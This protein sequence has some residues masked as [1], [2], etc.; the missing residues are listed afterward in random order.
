MKHARLSFLPTVLACSLTLLAA[1]LSACGDGEGGGSSGARPASS[2]K[3]A[4]KS[5]AKGAAKGAGGPAAKPAASSAMLAYELAQKHAKNGD[6]EQAEAEFRHAF[7][8]DPKMAEAQFELGRLQTQRAARKD[9]PDLQLLDQGIAAFAKACE[10]E[11]S[12]DRYRL[13]LGRA[14]LQ[15]DDLENAVPCLEKAL[16]LNPKSAGVWKALGQAQLA[17]GKAETGRDSLR[18]ALELNPRDAVANQLLAQ[19]LET[20]GDLPAARAACERALELDRGSREGLALLTELCRKLG[21]AEG[22]AKARTNLERLT[23][24]DQRMQERLRA[25]ELNPGDGVAQRH[26][27]EIYFEIGEWEQA[28]DSFLRAIT[29]DRRDWQAHLWCGVARRHLKDYVYAMHHL[30]EAEFLMPDVL[31]PKLELVRLYAERKD[32]AS[33][34]EVVQRVETEASGD[35]DALWFMAQVCK[36]VGRAEDAQRL[37]EKA[38]A[39]GVTAEPE[40]PATVEVQPG[41]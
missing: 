11:P 5:P 18:R 2:G 14:Y 24:F 21:D 26:L 10:L 9:P 41:K 4:A 8:L 3:A 6:M 30:K 35:G 22:E 29:I 27:G 12:N 17:G 34:K 36:E 28:R 39:L 32:E 23:E 7:E 19:A 20:L 13:Q 38:N 33:L 31:D 40:S 1:G 16:E 25:V 37:F 15:K